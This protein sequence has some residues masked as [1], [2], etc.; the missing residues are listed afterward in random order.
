MRNHLFWA[1]FATTTLFALSTAAQTPEPWVAKSNE[2]AQVLLRTIAKFQPESAAG[3]GIEGLDEE[4]GDPSAKAR[5]QYKRALRQAMGELA[6]RRKAEADA[7]VRQDLDIMIDDTRRTIRSMERTE[8]L[9]VPHLAV[10]ASVFSTLRSLLDDQVAPARRRAALVRLRR[11]AGMEQGYRPLAAIAEERVRAKLSK[12]G[13]RMPFRDEV[14]QRLA[15]STLMLDG[16]AGLFDKY[17]IT[18][19]Q[20]ALS[21]LRTQVGDYDAFVRN[22]LLPRTTTDFRLPRELYANALE[23]VGVDIPA[24]QLATTAR[25]AFVEIQAEMD[26]VANRLARERGWSVTGYRAVMRKLKEE[27]ITGE[28]ILPHYRSR[29]AQIEAIVRREKLVTLP[30]REARIRISSAAESANSPAPNMRPPRMLG[31]TGE[32]GEF[33]LPLAIPDASGKTQLAYDDFTYSAASW[34]LAAHELRPGH[35]LQFA[36]MVERGV[37]AARAIFA[38]NSTNVEGWGLYAEYILLPHMPLE[39]QLA[40]LNF[41][42]LRAARAFLDPELQAGTVTVAQATRILMDDVV[43][44]EAMAKQETDRYTFR[45]PGQATSYFYGYLRLMELR[46]EVEQRLGARFNALAFHDFVLD[47]GLLPPALL[48]AAVLDHFRG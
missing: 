23:G 32:M 48:R 33:V 39:G 43:C 15:Q 6:L 18:G 8:A 5:D 17:G 9:T 22:E 36:K 12:K 38:F 13:L 44:S 25:R 14:E 28:A 3:L 11:Y 35:E 40:S 45:S 34:S 2:H 4:I 27:Q 31:N 19:Y 37:S 41:R 47:Q 21:T 30:T 10:A 7:T 46:R 16:L 26:T 24:A 42:L 20:D 29:L 1:F